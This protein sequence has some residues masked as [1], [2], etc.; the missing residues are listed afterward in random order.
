[1]LA[2]EGLLLAYM[3]HRPI[4]DMAPHSHRSQ[5]AELSRRL[6]ASHAARAFSAA[7]DSYP[8]SAMMTDYARHM[9]LHGFRRPTCA[10]F[11]RFSQLLSA[12][13]CHDIITP[14]ALCQAATMEYFI[15]FFS[16]TPSLRCAL[17]ARD[18][19]REPSRRRARSYQRHATTG[20]C[21]RAHI[22]D[23]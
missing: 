5:R 20:R 14:A 8:A 13:T 21:R 17:R 1:M 22:Y 12:D 4:N 10:A 23:E 16:A 7:A 18:K 19:P 15:I 3:A 9:R 11:Y 2:A 6:E